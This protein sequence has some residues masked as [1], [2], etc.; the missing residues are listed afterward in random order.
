MSEDQNQMTAMLIIWLLTY[1]LGLYV[2]S[3]CAKTARQLTVMY[4]VFI[5]VLILIV[6]DR[7]LI[8]GD[9]LP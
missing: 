9:R 6:G 8:V 2:G 4:W 5:V 1:N 7:M 3:R